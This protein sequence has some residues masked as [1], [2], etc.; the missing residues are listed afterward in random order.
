MII[1]D[2]S[3]AFAQFYIKMIIFV[4]LII[5]MISAGLP[6][7]PSTTFGSSVGHGSVGQDSV[8]H[9]SYDDDL[10]RGRRDLIYWN[11]ATN[12]FRKYGRNRTK[13][14]KNDQNLIS[15]I[16]KYY[17]QKES[18]NPEKLKMIKNIIRSLEKSDKNHKI[19]NISAFVTKN[20]K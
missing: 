11:R 9:E 13:S 16:R 7:R 3:S 18:A 6:I 20:S 5:S 8:R 19:L 12:S 17:L 4:L 10:V 15:Q 14:D 1:D 2:E